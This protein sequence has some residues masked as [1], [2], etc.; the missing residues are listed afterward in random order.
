MKIPAGWTPQVFPYCAGLI[1]ADPQN[2]RGVVFLNGLH[3]DPGATLPPGVTPEEYLTTYLPRDFS[4]VSD[5]RILSYEDTDLSA[6]NTG[7]VTAKAMR[8]SFLNGGVP[9]TGSF[10][11]GTSQGAG[12]VT[13]IEY[14]WGI[15]A[16]T[17]SWEAD[18]PV[19]LESFFSID[20]SQATV[21][22]CKQILASA[23][24]A[25]S[26]SGGSAGVRAA[27]PA[28]SSSRS[29]MRSRRARTSSWRSS[30][31]IPSIVTASTTPRRTRSTPWTRTSTRYYDIHREQYRQQNMQQ[32]TDA[33]F[34]SHVALDG[35]LHIEPNT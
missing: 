29:G 25:G 14:L 28:S 23:W 17:T 10:M 7:S 26:R 18:A 11:V 19:L 22:G 32:L 13:P 6:L 12:Y 1:A 21:A 27:M 33:Q 2:Q 24:G 15:Y 4:T 30:R 5:V 34:R 20:Y 35:N 3:K 8:V 16:P 31:T 9:T